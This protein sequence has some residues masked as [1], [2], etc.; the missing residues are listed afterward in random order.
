MTMITSTRQVGGVTMTSASL[1]VYPA[2][3]WEQL[4]NKHSRILYKTVMHDIG[5]C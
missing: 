4:G 1:G 2:G 3:I 5:K